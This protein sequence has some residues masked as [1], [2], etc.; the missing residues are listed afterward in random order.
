MPHIPVRVP[1]A[2][3]AGL[4]FALLVVLLALAP[5]PAPGTHAG[6][7]PPL[8]ALGAPRVTTAADEQMSRLAP[9]LQ[10]AAAAATDPD[11][12]LPVIVVTQG[13]Y[14]GPRLTGAI[15]RRPDARG[16]VFT[17]GQVPAGQ[18]AGLARATNVVSV[19]SGAPPPPPIVPGL[20]SRVRPRPD[21]AGAQ[22]PGAA[23]VP[24]A[25]KA[26]P[27]A[28]APPAAAGA[29]G[30]ASPDSWHTVDVQDV[31]PAWDAGYRGDGVNVA[32]IDSG[33]D[34]GHPDLMNTY[35]RV[36]DP[37]SP[38]YGWPLAF[39]PTSMELYA[40]GIVGDLNNA[41]QAYGSWYV[42]TSAV[43]QGESGVFTTVGATPSAMVPITHTYQMPGTSLSGRYHI[44]ILPDEHLAFDRYG[45]YVA[46]VVAD[47]HQAGVYDT[48]YVDLLDTHDMRQAAVLSKGHEVGTTDLDHDGVP[49]LSTGMLYFIADGR[50][51]VP[52]SDWLY[53]LPAPDNGSLVAMMGS[54]DYAEDHGTSCAS[55][56]VAQGV[57]DGDNG[58]MRPPYKPAGVGGMVQ[59]M[60]PHAKIVA[61]GN[62]YRT[63]QAI[64]DAYIL[65]TYGLDGRPNTGDEPQ[66][67]SLS[68]GFDGGVDNGWDFQSRYLA[69]LQLDN[70]QISFVAAAGNGGPGY[71]SATPPAAGPSVISVGAATQYG[72]TTTFDPISSTRGITWGD[73]QPWSDRGP[74]VLGNPVPMVLAVGAWGTADVAPNYA[75][76]GAIAY[77]VW[78]GTSMATPVTAGVLAL[79]YQAYRQA[80]GHWPS[81]STARTLL[82]S[83][84]RD[85]HYDVFSQGA[86]LVDGWRLVQLAAGQAGLQVE[87][88]RWTPGQS[89]PAF[90]GYLVPGASDST[91]LTLTNP[92]GAPIQATVAA[93]QLQ[94]VGHYDWTVVT[95]NSRESGASFTR[96]DYLQDITGIIPADTDLMKVQAVFT[97]TQFTASAPNTP[98]L[99]WRNTWRLLTYDWTDKNGDG[100]LWQD[101]NGN[102]AV[103]DGEVQT[104]EY[105]RLWYSYPKGDMMEGFVE[106]P[107]ARVH[108]G[109]FVGLQHADA[110][111]DVPST[112]IHLHL[113]F[114]HHQPWPLAQVSAAPVVVPAHGS[115]TTQASIQ[116]P[117]DEEAGTYEGALRVTWNGGDHGRGARGAQR[118]AARAHGHLRRHAARAD[119]LRQW[120]GERRPQL[121]LAGRLRRVAPLLRRQPDRPAAAH[122]P[123]GAYRL[124]ALPDGH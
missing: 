33:V 11:T 67:A 48:V 85:L 112:T 12:L 61:I 113:T 53:G 124:A 39:D 79:G 119:H 50:H 115:A 22:A 66:I 110:S 20:E 38:Y 18:V 68:F 77:D 24:P 10:Q 123:V 41:I 107:L 29:G 109:L 94:E 46:M 88:V 65:A 87:P 42:D 72:E 15:T 28:P 7:A 83:S 102:G 70:P 49:D 59:G 73:V 34:F 98:W 62:V 37:A 23:P 100:R 16:L 78:G 86:G 55:S 35:A 74:S 104:G 60:A 19:L 57:I 82:A 92:T 89:A 47:T 17:S 14:S 30:G 36:T 44:G 91:V 75:R 117:A 84:A 121:G 3:W 1:A 54:Y 8:Q 6:A 27:A 97:Y 9:A 80:T 56:I 101:L 51:S 64:Y 4:P 114:Y 103:N 52:G 71:G 93:E 5:L 2:R 43:I 31:R 63:G 45:E 120:P 96:P 99:F 108:D 32:V 106:Q 118:R 90:A 40:N 105:N 13:T 76:H 122:V 21:H 26:A 25:G 111:G 81:A 116:V 95:N 58:G 69:L